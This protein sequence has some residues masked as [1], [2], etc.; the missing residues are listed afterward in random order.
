MADDKKKGPPAAPS[1]FGKNHLQDTILFLIVL[2]LLGAII[3]R[4]T[5]Y[6]QGFDTTPFSSILDYI[7]AWLRTLWRV[8]KVVAVFVAVGLA[9]WIWHSYSKLRALKKEDEQI[10]GVV[11]QDDFLNKRPEEKGNEKW[12]HVL[13]LMNSSNPS[14][15]R[16]AIM[17]A[18]IMLDE[19]LRAQRYHGD[20]VGEMLKSVEESDM[21]TLDAAWEAHKVRNRIAHSGADFELNERETKR[22]LALFESVFK[23]FEII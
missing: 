21:S 3:A 16:L 4:I 10:Y 5:Y 6:F 23:E 15:W 14:E 11:P 19:M 17:E 9:G 8:W 12:A 13:E 20:S 18:D 7:M 22:V 1:P 2:I